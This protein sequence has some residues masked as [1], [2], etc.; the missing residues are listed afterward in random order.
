MDTSDFIMR[1]IEENIAGPADVGEGGGIGVLRDAISLVSRTRSSHDFA[2]SS[3]AT[4][5]FER[6]PANL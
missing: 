1:K 6:T 5:G 4:F 2:A 3:F